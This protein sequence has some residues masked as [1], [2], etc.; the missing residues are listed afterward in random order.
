[1]I[2]VKTTSKNTE[3]T[4]SKN[5]GKIGQACAAFPV[6]PQHSRGAH[7]IPGEPAACVCVPL[8]PMTPSPD[9]TLSNLACNLPHSQSSHDSPLV[10]CDYLHV[11]F[12]R[13]HP[14]LMQGRCVCLPQVVYK[15]KAR[16]SLTR[17]I[18]LF[19]TPASATPRF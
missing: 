9:S 1:M 11:S 2:T 14:S 5:T 10:L 8:L 7:G 12:S 16:F 15:P 3:S 4:E 19:L 6:S 18:T 13:K 17:D